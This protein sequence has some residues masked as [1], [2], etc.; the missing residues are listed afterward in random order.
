MSNQIRVLGSL[1]IVVASIGLASVPRATT[2][3]FLAYHE[4]ENIVFSPEATGTHRR[5]RLG[6]WDF[7]ERLSPADEKPRDK[8][9]NLYVV[10]P[11]AQ[12]RSPTHPEYDHNL[13]VNKYVVDGK[14][15]EWDIFWCFVLD[16]TLKAD[17]RGE[18]D[19]LMAAHETFQLP[20][21]FQP[22]RLA[23]GAVLKEK[24]S[25]TGVESLERFRRKDGSFPRLLIVP[26][27][28]ALS[29]VAEREPD[30]PPVPPSNQ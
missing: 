28:L 18:H 15:R 17:L 3:P 7:G 1:G 25:V 16:P 27:R 2:K 13:V 10:V 19:L 21:N 29:A 9:L 4:G 22:S 6:P 26:A 23:A 8:R 30:G 11:G 20:E 24:V 5:A 12:Y 14:P